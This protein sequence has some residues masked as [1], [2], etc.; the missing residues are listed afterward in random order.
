MNLPKKSNENGSLPPK[1][2]LKTS[3]GFRN[4]KPN[5]N[6]PSKWLPPTEA[7]TAQS[8]TPTQQAHNY[9]L[10]N[11]TTCILTQRRRKFHKP[12]A[13][14]NPAESKA[15]CTGSWETHAGQH[16]R[17]TCV[18]R[19]PTNSGRVT[20]TQH[21]RLRNRCSGVCTGGLKSACPNAPRGA[22]RQQVTA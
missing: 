10:Q 17:A 19:T 9:C 5:S 21:F 4:V 2:S 18:Q 14:S 6:G 15:S 7:I 20:S 16:P 12:E 11:I 8:G 3:S 1:N 22:H 13:R